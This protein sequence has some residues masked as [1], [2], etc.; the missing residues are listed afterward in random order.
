MPGMDGVSDSLRDISTELII[1]LYDNWECYAVGA[2]IS[3]LNQNI[4]KKGIYLAI[5]DRML[6]QAKENGKLNLSDENQLG[7]EQLK[8]IKEG[9]YVPLHW[10]LR[11]LSGANY[12][13]QI[14]LR[15]V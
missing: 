13:G 5:I 15:L 7:I 10:N 2:E 12:E 9:G 4:A 3:Y 8:F 1:D 11:T 14:I 6:L